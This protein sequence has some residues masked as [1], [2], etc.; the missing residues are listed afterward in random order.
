MFS[1]IWKQPE[2]TGVEESLTIIRSGPPGIWSVTHHHS[3]P[4]LSTE[5]LKTISATL[6]QFSGNKELLLSVGIRNIFQPKM[7]RKE[8]SSQPGLTSFLPLLLGNLLFYDN[9]LS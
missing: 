1:R 8:V 7:T 6:I 9:N 4:F 3:H 2:R 5:N